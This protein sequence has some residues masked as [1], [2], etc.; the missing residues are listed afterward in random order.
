MA[1]LVF[2]R[3]S[4]QTVLREYARQS[5]A[6]DDVDVQTVFDPDHDHYQV[7]NVGW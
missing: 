3:S 4:I 6:S 7:V 1:T 2:L 5:T